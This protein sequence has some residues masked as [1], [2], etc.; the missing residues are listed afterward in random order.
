MSC[1]GKGDSTLLLATTHPLI[2]LV[3]F[4]A[5]L[6]AFLLLCCTALRVSECVSRF[7]QENILARQGAKAVANGM[8]DM[9]AWWAEQIHQKIPL[10]LRLLQKMDPS[11]RFN[12]MSGVAS[13]MSQGLSN[14]LQPDA[15]SG[16]NELQ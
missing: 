16:P 9:G 8:I 3:L 13:S 15:L 5:V 14:S 10:V 4:L 6:L 11:Q 2:F 1:K 7:H 12:Q